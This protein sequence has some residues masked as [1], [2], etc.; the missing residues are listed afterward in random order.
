MA[1]L[2]NRVLPDG[3]IVRQNWRGDM[4]GNRG[5]R[6]HD[7]T[8]RELTGR[9]WASKRWIICVTQ[10]RGRQR[11]VMGPGYTELFFLDEVSALAAGHRPCFECRRNAANSFAKHWESAHGALFGSRAD[12]MD[13]V[14]HHERTSQRE[15]ELTSNVNSLPDGVM[16]SD[17]FDYF[18]CRGGRLLKWSGSG[19]SERTNG[20]TGLFILTPPATVAVLKSGYTP[21]WHVS[22]G[23]GDRGLHG[24]S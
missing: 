24:H 22:A 12:A 15:N 1:G 21:Q 9:N 3:H 17:G 6:I 18:A 8:T 10:F 5:G 7:P 2:Q 13:R 19:Y 4:M 14:L 16:V 20:N 23:G 11:R